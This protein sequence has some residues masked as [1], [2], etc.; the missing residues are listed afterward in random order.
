MAEEIEMPFGLWTWVG[1]RKHVLYGTQIPNAKGQLLGGKDMPGHA[2][3]HFVMSYAKW[4]NQS[5]CS[6]G[7]GLRWAEGNTNSIVFARWR[8]CAFWEG[9]L[10]WRQVANTIEPSICRGD[11]TLCQITLTTCLLCIRNDL[12]T[13]L[14]KHIPPLLTMFSPYSLTFLDWL[15][16]MLSR[17]W[18]CSLDLKGFSILLII[19]VV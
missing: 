18:L 8:Q 13:T 5:I 14:L 19:T 15:H 4:L 2:R 10:A 11:A 1:P 9:T 12:H 17:I 7:C 16:L 3:Q 6:L